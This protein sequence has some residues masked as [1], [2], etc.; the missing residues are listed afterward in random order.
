MNNNAHV[1][2]RIAEMQKISSLNFLGDCAQGR[3]AIK[4]LTPYKFSFDNIEK[5]PKVFHPKADRKNRRLSPFASGE[6]IST[7]AHFKYVRAQ[8]L[9]LLEYLNRD[10]QKALI[11]RFCQIFNEFEFMKAYKDLTTIVNPVTS[12]LNLCVFEDLTLLLDDVKRQEL[13]DTVSVHCEHQFNNLTKTAFRLGWS[14]DKLVA[15]SYGLLVELTAHY[16]IKP[17]YNNK[18]KKPLTAAQCESGILRFL[19][20]EYWQGKFDTIAKRT[21]EHVAI[22]LGKVRKKY[23][24]YVSKNALQD[25]KQQLDNNKAYLEMMD[26]INTG[27]GDKQQLAELVALGSANPEKR[28]IELMVRCR[29]LEDIALKEGKEAV[30]FTVTSPSKYHKNSPKWN[31]SSPRDTSDYLCTVWAQLR[32]QLAR[33]GID[34]NGVR[35]SEPHCDGTPHWH[36]LM[37]VEPEKRDLLINTF[38]K[39]ATAEDEGELWSI[40]EKHQVAVKNKKNKHS[41]KHWYSPRFVA[42]IIDPKKGSATGYIAKYISKNI[43]GSKMEG[44]IDDEAEIAVC[45][46]AQR[47]TAWASLWAI[48]QFQFFGA[49]SVSVWRECRRAKSA[50]D[51]ANMELVRQAADKGDWQEFTGQMRETKLVLSYEDAEETNE[52]NELITRVKGVK[53][54]DLVCITRLESFEL[55]KRSLS[56]SWSPVINCTHPKNEQ[57]N[58]WALSDKDKNNYKKMGFDDGSLNFLLSGNAVFIRGQKFEVVNGQLTSN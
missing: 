38:R 41:Q 21:N 44:E 32:A 19:D 33:E 2:A 36:L 54:A 7:H 43:N 48:R 34:Y 28:R 24:P 53:L 37:F 55:Q 57:K 20:G 42:E 17:P 22:A 10:F 18:G 25:Y 46:S 52:Y 49:A 40:W 11:N 15:K 30:F 31:L 35:V 8:V 45:E 29:G 26:V 14:F 12:V 4:A 47:V 23:S 39:Y 50:F 51:C 27:T 58:N 3:K 9:P 13:G 56:L 16:K 6:I 5:N 1:L